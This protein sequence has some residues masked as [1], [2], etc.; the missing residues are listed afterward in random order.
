VDDNKREYYPVRH[1]CQFSWYCDGKT[2]P[3]ANK[4]SVSWKLAEDVAYQ[5]LAFDK[6]NG[7]VEGAT[8]YHADYVSPHWRKSMRLITKIDDHIFYREN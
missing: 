4:Q 8:H 1:K 7:M 2:D 6:W 3:P 5:I